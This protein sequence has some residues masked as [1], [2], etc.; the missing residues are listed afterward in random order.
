MKESMPHDA[1]TDMY[2]CFH[3]VDDFNKDKGWSDIFFNK[4]HVSPEMAKHHQ[5]FG[6]VEDAINL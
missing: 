4:K 6:E 2:W 1:F 5:K 3:F